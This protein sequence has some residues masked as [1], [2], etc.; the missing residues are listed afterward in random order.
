MSKEEKLKAILKILVKEQGVHIASDS[1]TAHEILRILNQ[2]K[3]DE[4]IIN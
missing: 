3:E 4:E 2:K 1:I